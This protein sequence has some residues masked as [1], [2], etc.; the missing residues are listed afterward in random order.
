M[1]FQKSP[2]N[3]AAV[4]LLS[5]V[6]ALPSTPRLRAAETNSHPSAAEI[7][8]VKKLLKQTPLIDGHNDVPWQYR[9]RAN[10]DI[11]AIDLAG[12]TSKL[13]P[14]MVTD[15]RRLRAGGVGGQFWSVYIPPTLNG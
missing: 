15:I 14:P 10:D 2:C 11:N 1:I 5:F 13:T 7:A 6:M 12:D 4:A 8:T 3:L 9:K